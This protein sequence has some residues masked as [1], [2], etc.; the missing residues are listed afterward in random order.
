MTLPQRPNFEGVTMNSNSNSWS[1][2]DLAIYRKSKVSDSPGS[3]AKNVTP[4]KKGDSY[5]YTVDKYWVVNDC[6]L[7]VTLRGKE[8]LVSLGDIALRKPWF[9]ERCLLKRRHQAL[10]STL[11]MAR[12]GDEPNASETSR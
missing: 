5:T 1:I 7:L 2:G 12:L 6:L 8:H 10:L 11:D 4:S 9:W 3:R